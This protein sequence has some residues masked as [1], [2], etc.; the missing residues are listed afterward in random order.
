[1]KHDLHKN[2][3]SGHVIT[4]QTLANNI[5]TTIIPFLTQIGVSI[6][7]IPPDGIIIFTPGIYKLT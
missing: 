4:Y 3:V 2:I 5:Q 6:S 7:T 1:M